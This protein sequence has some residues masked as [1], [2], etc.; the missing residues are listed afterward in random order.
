LKAA[1]GEH[2]WWWFDGAMLRKLALSRVPVTFRLNFFVSKT[3]VVTN[4]WFRFAEMEPGQE[5]F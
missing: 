1:V 2:L 5:P 4:W 3:I